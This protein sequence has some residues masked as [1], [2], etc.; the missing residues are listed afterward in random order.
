MRRP[1]VALCALLLLFIAAACDS[2]PG[3]R[4]LQ[5]ADDPQTIA[6]A[7]VAAGDLVMADKTTGADPAIVAAADRIEAA[8]SGLVDV[9]E[10]REF[11]DTSTFAVNMLFNP[12]QV[13]GPTAQ[14]A[15]LEAVRRAFELAWLGGMPFSADAEL[16]DVAL[17]VPQDITTIDTGTAFV[18]FIIVEGAIE[19][20]AAAAYLDGDRSLETFFDLVVTG[21]LNYQ[22][23]TS[24]VIYDGSPNHPLTLISNE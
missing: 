7:A 19:R 10:I 21:T 22:Q 15:E 6:D 17:M 11:P 13:E 12:P 5:G 16:L 2:L 23:L 24:P 14:I 9:I 3:L 1:V 4:V 18:G 20:S 8:A